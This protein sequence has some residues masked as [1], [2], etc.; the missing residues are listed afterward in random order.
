ML[1]IIKAAVC[2]KAICFHSAASSRNQ[3]RRWPVTEG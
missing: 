1:H 3:K 2:P